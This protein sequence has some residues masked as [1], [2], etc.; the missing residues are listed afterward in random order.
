MV[1]Q[2]LANGIIIDSTYALSLPSAWRSSTKP[3]V[4]PFRPWYF[5]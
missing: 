5:E 3:P 2:L 4:S 1:K